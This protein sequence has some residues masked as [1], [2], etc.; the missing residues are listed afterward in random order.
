M[1]SQNG[2]N[3]KISFESVAEMAAEEGFVLAGITDAAGTKYAEVLN[4]WLDAGKHGEMGYLAEHRE[5]RLDPQ[6]LLAGAK[7]VICV[8]DA[9]FPIAEVGDLEDGGKL[10]ERE[11]QRLRGKVARYAW[12]RDYHKVLKK[13]LFRV[14]DRLKEQLPSEGE[15]FRVTTDTAPLLER[16]YAAR[17]GL[18]WIG[19]HTLLIHPQLGSYHLLGAIVTTAALPCTDEADVHGAYE[20]RLLGETDHCGSCRRCI[21]ACPT[22]CID[23]AGYGMD[24]S[25]CISYLSL[26]HRSVIEVG[27]AEQMGDWVAGCDV[28]QE[29][30]PHNREGQHLP[31]DMIF[32]GYQPK[33]QLAEGLDLWA[34]L[35]WTAEDR[36]KVFEGSAIKRVK[37]EM[38]KRNAVIA[39]T[40]AAM[41]GKMNDDEMMQLREK[42]VAMRED[43]DEMIAAQAQQSI[44]RL[45]DSR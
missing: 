25:R 43:E 2:K 39:M 33:R 28:C 16:E 34:V 5:V 15:M 31:L 41:S 37:L 17:A 10:C 3:G 45:D 12:G 11:P 4:Q 29:V 22:G 7:S 21:E 35:D 8:A 18:G 44:D 42:L 19:K 23:E 30:C 6:K 1:S 14:A 27:L 38:I 40:N 32:E 24:G 20:G 26:E 9:Y 36:A 13:R